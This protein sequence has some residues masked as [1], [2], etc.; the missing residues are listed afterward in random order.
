MPA[1]LQV[2]HCQ[3]VRAVIPSLPPNI[4]GEP[5]R[6]LQLISHD[7]SVSAIVAMMFSAISSVILF[8][9]SRIS[10]TLSMAVANFSLYVR[11]FLKIV[12]MI[13]F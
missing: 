11:S 9:L 2:E 12:M 1:S 13:S 7:A 5:S 10:L 8:A 6:C 3:V 4:A